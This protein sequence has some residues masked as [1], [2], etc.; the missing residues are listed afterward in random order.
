MNIW[1]FQTGEPLHCDFGGLRPMRAVNLANA[2]IAKGHSVVIWAAAFDHRNKCHRSK[3]FKVINLN[4]QLTIN[5][6]PSRGYFRH[7]GIARLFDHAQLALNLSRALNDIGLSNPDAAFVGF[8]PIEAAWVILKW[9]KK[10]NIPSIIDVKDQWPSIFLEISPAFFRPLIKAILFPYFYLTR[11]ALL[12]ATV[13]CSMSR[14]FLGWMSRISGRLLNGNDLVIPLTAPRPLISEIE[15]SE[16]FNWWKQW[17]VTNDSKR[18]FCFVGSLSPQFDFSL[19][20][21]VATVFQNQLIDCQ[22]VICG[23]GSSSSEIRNMMSGLENVIFPG[24]IDEPKIQA[25]A[26]VSCASLA[27]YKNSE[28]FITNIPNKITDSLGYGLPII[29]TL[30]GE[31]KN[32]IEDSNV[33]F[34]IDTK[35]NAYEAM[36]LLL[37]SESIQSEMSHRA[38]KLYDKE[39][40]YE[41]SYGRLVAKLEEMASK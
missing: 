39:F 5:L 38:H 2:L 14:G 24:W 17:S 35:E 6:I 33:G 20:R 41:K 8:P 28:N 4:N 30:Q 18:R 32:I 25:L 34:Y 36:M 21:D 31:V 37:V 15:L 1:I 13:F 26:M 19:I 7:I 10:R 9:L 16:A 11:Q 40:S 12:N 29:S 23:D 27:P 3:V 22:F